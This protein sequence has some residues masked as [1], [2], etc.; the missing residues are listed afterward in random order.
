MPGITATRGLR[1][2]KAPKRTDGTR[3]TQASTLPLAVRKTSG[4][5]QP[6]SSSRLRSKPTAGQARMPIRSPSAWGMEV[7]LAPVSTMKRTGTAATAPPT[8]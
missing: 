1:S 8:S 4:R 7:R 2:S 5:Q 6:G 3:A